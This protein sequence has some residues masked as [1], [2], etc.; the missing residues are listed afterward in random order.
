VSRR[1]AES[2][3]ERYATGAKATPGGGIIVALPLELIVYVPVVAEI[4]PKIVPP[5]SAS[6]SSVRM[7]P[8]GT[9]LPKAPSKDTKPMVAADLSGPDDGLDGSTPVK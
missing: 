4:G 5:I 6:K 8:V 9:G 2:R 7:L 1:T 3:S